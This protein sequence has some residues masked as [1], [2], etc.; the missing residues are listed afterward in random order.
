MR[1]SEIY[2]RD[3]RN[4]FKSLQKFIWRDFR[5]LLKRLRNYLRSSEIYWRDS[6]IILVL[7]KFIEGTIEIIMNSSE[8]YWR[9]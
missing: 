6:E 7:K 5:N 4:L 8:I 2:R 1:S 9:D 3:Y